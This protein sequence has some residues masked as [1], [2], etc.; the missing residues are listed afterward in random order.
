M[1][2]RLA[3]ASGLRQSA[4]HY[5][6]LSEVQ[7]TTH[8]EK[9]D[10]GIPCTFPFSSATACDDRVDALFRIS[11]RQDQPAQQQFA[12]RIRDLLGS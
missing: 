1:P 7:H 4:L 2:N 11:A 10:A 8:G 6:G 12:H 5:S 3:I 9:S